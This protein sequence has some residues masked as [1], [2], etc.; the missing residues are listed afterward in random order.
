MDIIKIVETLTDRQKLA[1]MKSVAH[2]IADNRLLRNMAKGAISAA[3]AELPKERYNVT[4]QHIRNFA[5]FLIE[6]CDR[7]CEK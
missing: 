4:R 1:Q 6:E 5:Q 2:E 3:I 7:D